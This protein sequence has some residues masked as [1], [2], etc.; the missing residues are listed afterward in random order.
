MFRGF[1]GKFKLRKNTADSEIQFLP[2]ACL[3]KFK[4]SDGLSVLDLALAAALPLGHSCGGNGY[5]T[6]CRV[7]IE[8]PSQLAP[9]R[10][11]IES[12]IASERCFLENERLACQLVAYNGLI[13]SRPE[14]NPE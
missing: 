5:C 9:E 1:S 14:E 3:V 6:T 8:S 4:S 12:E 10:N 13:V 11:E 7:F 2:E